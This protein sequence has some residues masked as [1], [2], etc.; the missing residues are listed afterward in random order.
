M[1]SH[2]RCAV[3]IACLAGAAV[4][5]AQPLAQLELPSCVLGSPPLSLSPAAER[6]Q[7]DGADRQ[8]FQRAAQMRYPAYSR[9]GGL[10]PA[11]V[12]ML[13]RGGGWQYVT[14]LAGGP[15]GLCFSAVFA[16][17]RFDF[18]PA[19]LAK[20]KPRAAEPAD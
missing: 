16:A 3:V 12:L 18:T 17:E 2:P 8:R 7:L 4:A 9:G 19:W 13:R 20:Y 15:A 11:Q 14:I 1:Q 5:R 6:A 10:V